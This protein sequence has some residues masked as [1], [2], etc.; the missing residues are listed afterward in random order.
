MFSVLGPAVAFA[1]FLIAWTFFASAGRRRA[2]AASFWLCGLA[3]LAMGSVGLFQSVRTWRI[4]H[5]DPPLGPMQ[6]K[7]Y[8]IR[9]GPLKGLVFRREEGIPFDQTLTYLS[10][11]PA[12]RRPVFVYPNY[13]AFNTALGEVAPH[14][15]LFF[16]PLVNYVPGSA[17]DEMICSSVRK[18]RAGTILLTQEPDTL[19]LACVT[20]MVRDEF[21]FDRKYEIG[22][23]RF[24]IYGRRS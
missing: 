14:P 24:L 5:A 10:A 2:G 22:R 18:S 3:G 12:A 17:D 13:P 6:T 4:K 23:F 21:V 9:S 19:D 20:R 7:D 16:A 8:A 11:L 1:G 15:I